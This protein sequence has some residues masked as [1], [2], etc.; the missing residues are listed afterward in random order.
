MSGK[1]PRLQDGTATVDMD[2]Y[3][4]AE[5]PPSGRKPPDDKES[6]RNSNATTINKER[7]NAFAFELR[8]HNKHTSWNCRGISNRVPY[9]Q[10][11]A[12]EGTHIIVL[13]EHWLWPYQL[14]KLETMHPNYLAAGVADKRLTESSELLRGCGGIAMLPGQLQLTSEPLPLQNRS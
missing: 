10:H 6:V 8:M 12:E 9:V 11:M 14:H 7:Y 1:Q 3:R 2:K 4:L 5:I 13:C